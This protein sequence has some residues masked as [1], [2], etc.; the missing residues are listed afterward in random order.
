MFYSDIFVYKLFLIIFGFVYCAVELFLERALMGL[1]KRLN[2]NRVLVSQE[3]LL[4]QLQLM[5]GISMKWLRA[6]AR[7][8]LGWLFPVLT[9]STA[10]LSNNCGLYV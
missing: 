7:S 8:D 9:D 2:R 6:Y 1:M 10:M 5:V 3:L 4:L